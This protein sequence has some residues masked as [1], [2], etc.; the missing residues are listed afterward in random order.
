MYSPKIKEAYI[1]YLYRLARHLRIPM[2]HLVNQI[3]EPVIE[4]FKRNG[5]YA[6]L[7]QEQQA[8]DALTAHFTR[9]M[10]SRKTETAEVIELLRK[11]S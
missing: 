1:P 8:I 7:E 5:I 2:T 11:I 4:R 3:V 9:L 10:N 6:E